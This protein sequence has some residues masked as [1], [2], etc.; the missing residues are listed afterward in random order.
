MN[1][2]H[3]R[4]FGLALIGAVILAAVFGIAR[5]P[6]DI[7]QAQSGGTLGY[8]SKVY[9]SIS[10]AAP[11]VT[12]S[13]SGTPG[14]F[15]AIS[16]ETWT[17][18]LDIQIDLVAPNGLVL[19]H[20]TQNAAS[21]DP[22]GATLS[23]FLPDTGVYLLRISGENGTTG[24]YLLTLLGRSAA[25]T[26]PLVFGQAVDVTI[27]QDALPQY[28]SFEAEDCPTTLIVTN[29]GEGQPFTYPFV[30]KVRDQ[31]GQTVAL[32]RG[33]EQVEDWVTVQPNSGRYEVEVGSA[34]PTLAG[35]VRLLVTCSGD[36]PGCPAGVEGLAL[37][38]DCRPCPGPDTLIPGGG[39]PDLNLTVQQGLHM[40][41]A[42]TVSWDPMPG[43]EGYVVYVY[44]LTTDGGEV[45]LT[46]AEWVPGDPTEFTWILPT[47]GYIGYRFALEVM[48][49]G[50]VICT[51][52]AR[53]NI[54]QTSPDCPDLGLAAV[55]TDPAVN[56]VALSWAAGLGADQFDLD[57]YSIIGAG[58]EYSGRLVLPGDATGRDFDHFPP[59]LDGVRFVLWMWRD[60]QLCVDEVTVM[61]D[62]DLQHVCPPLGLTV[63]A[64]DTMAHTI[65]LTWFALE[66]I[67]GYE[68]DVYGTPDGGAEAL[69]DS[70][71]VIPAGVTSTTYTYPDGYASFRFVLRLVG[72]PIECSEEIVVFPQGQQQREC[73]DFDLAVT[74]STGSQVDLVWTAYPGADGYAYLLMDESRNPV[75][76][77]SV[78]LS[79][80]QLN[81]VLLSPP[82]APGTY[83]VSIGPWDSVDG[84]FCVRE[85]TIT[86]GGAPGEPCAIRT[87]Q[88]TVP[89]RVGPGLDRAI[90]TWLPIGTDI[91]VVGQFTDTDG[92]LWWEIDKS[93]IPGGDAAISLWVAANDVTEVGDCTE[94][95]PGEVPEVVPVEPVEP[96]EPSPGGWGECGSCD[97]CGHPA[98][99]CVLSPDGLCLWDPATCLGGGP[100]PVGE[101]CYSVTAAIDMGQCFGGGSAMI[102]TPPNCEGGG[103]SPGT[104]V[105]AH[106]VA[107]DPKCHV[108]SW[109]GCGASGSGASVSFVPPGSCT[110]TAHMGY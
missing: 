19:D 5:T 11:L 83:I 6:T 70:M 93:A 67:D 9:G 60:G 18:T 52:Q 92:N 12:Y 17:G 69:L 1:H 62:H 30:A 55:V 27:P 110:V 35:S 22:M 37:G 96:V 28:F 89:V 99:E 10:A 56:A 82:L 90:F 98:S 29:P 33:G 64:V 58:E 7:T 45:Y 39:C 13:F 61:F 79:E 40:A 20:S 76:G 84:A 68:L 97:T 54:E 66:E 75:P 2:K 109:S 32:L 86:F 102:D 25:T 85:V 16:A 107:V 108:L 81:L 50:G 95:P 65:T 53:I 78:I 26:T 106:A 63:A 4:W 100:P 72:G 80:T 101:G 14:D 21:G 71:G 8:G 46:H 94:V 44:G 31:R 59:L 105:S 3:T 49:E 38:T 103:Y 57:V 74:A 48:V 15:V 87:D 91:L 36:N 23:V 47:E 43:A 77:H 73:A 34:D 104:T 88:Q 51:Q 41:T 42:T 24:D